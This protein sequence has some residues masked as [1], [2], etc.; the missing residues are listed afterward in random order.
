MARFVALY[1][2]GKYERGSG[3][4]SSWIIGIAR[5]CILEQRRVRAVR[6]EKRGLSALGN[7]PDE[8]HLSTIWE[9]ESERAILCK[10]IRTLREETRIDANTIRAFELLALRQ[11]A[12]SEVAAEL[13][14]TMNDVYLAKHRCL[15][16]LRPLVAALTAAYTTDQ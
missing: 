7:L 3:R 13:D 6:R 16:R 5:N 8:N 9:R 2:A 15:K 10:A 4:L 1:R 11:L 12:P 14:M